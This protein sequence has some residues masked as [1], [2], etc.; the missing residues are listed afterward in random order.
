MLACIFSFSG[1]SITQSPQ[2]YTVSPGGSAVFQ[3][4]ARFLNRRTVAF[5]IFGENITTADINCTTKFF[6]PIRTCNRVTDSHPV[7]CAGC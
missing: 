6:T 7:S 3:C 5:E 1:T 4:T 2:N